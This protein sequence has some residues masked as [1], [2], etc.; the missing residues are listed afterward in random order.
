VEEAVIATGVGLLAA[1]PVAAMNSTELCGAYCRTGAVEDIAH[2]LALLLHT[3]LVS[4]AFLPFG[5]IDGAFTGLRSGSADLTQGSLH[6]T[7]SMD[8]AKARESDVFLANSALIHRVSG[9]V[10]LENFSRLVDRYIIDLWQRLVSER[11]L[12][13]RFCERSRV[14]SR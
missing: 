11:I 5:K 1:V 6:A 3:V 4:I 8:N 2:S 13:T 12:S 7:S 14:M 10:N 9:L